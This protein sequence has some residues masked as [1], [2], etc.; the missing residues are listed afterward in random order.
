MQADRRLIRV[1]GELVGGRLAG[2]DRHAHQLERQTEGVVVDA[3]GIGGGDV[4]DG[5]LA[6]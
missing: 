4:S 5:D 1:N 6:G 2:V 3:W